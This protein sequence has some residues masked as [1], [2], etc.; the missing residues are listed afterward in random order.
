MIIIIIIII[1]IIVLYGMCIINYMT[2][3]NQLGL[4]AQSALSVR[5]K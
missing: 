3:S 5:R 1:I 4:L 2:Y